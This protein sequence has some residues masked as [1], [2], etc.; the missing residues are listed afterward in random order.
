MAYAKFSNKSISCSLRSKV[1]GR[2]DLPEMQNKLSIYY[3]STHEDK[4]P[5]LPRNL[6]FLCYS[7]SEVLATR[8]MLSN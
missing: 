5:I 7:L 3:C 8:F 1:N 2:T 6:Y 4:T